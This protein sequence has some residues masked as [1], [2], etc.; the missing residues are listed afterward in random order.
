MLT[1]KAQ[2]QKNELATLIYN[3]VPLDLRGDAGRIQQILTN[4]IG[5]AVKFTKDGDIVIRV[6]KIA[7]TDSSVRLKF[8]VADTGEGISNNV[9]EK[10]FQPFTQ[11]D[12]STTRRFGGTG[13]GL[14]ICKRLVEMMNGEIGVQSEIGKGATFWF[15]ISLEK[16]KLPI[17]VNQT[18]VNSTVTHNALEGRRVLVVD[19]NEINRE[20]LVY[21]MRSW[22]M[23][24]REA[25]DGFEAIEI[26]KAAAQSEKPIDLVILDL[27]MPGIDGL[28]TARRMFAEIKTDEMSATPAA[29]LLSSSIMK[30]SSENL[31]D[32]AISASLN[33][34]YRQTDLLDAIYETLDLNRRRTSQNFNIHK[35]VVPSFKS[36]TEAVSDSRAKNKRILLVE[37]NRV[38]QMVAQTHLKKFGYQADVAGNGLEAIKALEMLPYHLVLMDCQMPEMD[39]YEATRVIRARKW[40]AARIPII[41]LTA[42]AIEG[43]REKCL[44]AGMNDYISKPVQKDDL[45]KILEQW[46]TNAEEEQDETDAPESVKEMDTEFGEINANSVNEQILTVVNFATLNDITDNDPVMRREIVEMYLA[47][48]TNQLDEIE[49]AITVNDALTLSNVAHKTVGGSALCGMVA[50]VEPL[51]ELER[52]GLD[53]KT[54][55]AAPLLAQARQAFVSINEQCLE[56]LEN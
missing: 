33:K 13:L 11:S 15:D 44:Q 48:T 29:I 30:I 40:K 24:V 36:N 3:D 22:S 25:T 2:S 5:N 50:I 52:M 49:R 17:V 45:Q 31:R 51:R 10:L 23:E 14:S 41:A 34:P 19:D 1:A 18:E 26:L 7:E 4:L 6:K 21:Q 28:E 37:D 9:Q 38:N 27:N 54:D 43:E 55:E 46:L 20:I 56:I 32:S 39:G 53:G 16:Q 8:S 47:Q 35:S 12:A 42:H